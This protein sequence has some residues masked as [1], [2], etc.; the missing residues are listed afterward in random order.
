MSATLYLVRHAAP[1]PDPR[2]S[3]AEWRLSVDGRRAAEQL[4]ADW[5]GGVLAALYSSPEPKA[6]QTA[7]PLA[8][9]FGID[10]QVR[11]CLHE[12]QRPTGWLEDYRRRVADY[13]S[14]GT[15]N[16]WEPLPAAQQRIVACVRAV[17]AEAGEGPVAV[18]SHGMALTL[19]LAALRGGPPSFT[20]WRFMLMPSVAE[21]DPS[22]WQLVRPFEIPTGPAHP[23]G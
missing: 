6:I 19:L 14:G 11:E 3:P 13:L 8:K 7:E 21:I 22:A 18:V 15:L 10:V 16:G 12:V 17:A 5:P 9:R 4:A 20:E 1:A 23:R 2:R